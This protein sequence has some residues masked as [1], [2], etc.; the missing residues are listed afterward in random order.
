MI[1]GLRRFDVQ[2]QGDTELQPIRSYEN[3]TL[4]RL[5][6]RLSSALNERVSTALS[7]LQVPVPYY[8]YTYD[9]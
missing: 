4:V 6:Y 9:A 8:I 1:N 2:Y 5:L 7:S 3:A